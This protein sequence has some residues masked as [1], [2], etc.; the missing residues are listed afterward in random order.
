MIKV[1]KTKIN[2]SEI[3]V[4]LE[5]LEIKAKECRQDIKKLQEE[6]CWLMKE[7]DIDEMPN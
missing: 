5:N 4:R 3:I 2:F 7:A 6:M 1:E